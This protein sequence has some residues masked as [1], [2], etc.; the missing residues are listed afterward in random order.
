[1]TLFALH[2]S[3]C[4][5]LWIA[6]H[7]RD[8]EQTW[9]GSQVRGFTDRSVWVGYT[10]A[11]YWSIT[12]LATVGYGD[13]HAVNPGEMA[14]ATAYMLFNL[15]LTSYIIGNM[16]NLIV[17]AATNTFTMRDMLRR[18]STF[19][20]ANQLPRELREQM[21]ASAQLRFNAGEV[22]QQQQLLSDLPRALRSGVARHLFGDTVRRCYLFQGVSGGLVVQLVSEMAAEYFPP[23][24][25]IVLQNETSTDCYIVVSGAVVSTCLRTCLQ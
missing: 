4:I 16:T 5:F 10:Y 15:G 7:H 21:T 1:V 24:A 20:S 8:K 9:L 12:T 19:G 25:D 6:F 22:V 11:V 17:H 23:K 13:L 3:A 2:S 18:V 14:F